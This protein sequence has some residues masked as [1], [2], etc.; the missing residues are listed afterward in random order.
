MRDV[1]LLKFFLSFF[2]FRRES[3]FDSKIKFSLP[4]KPLTNF[5][6][7]CSQNQNLESFDFP[8]H[9]PSFF[10]L[11]MPSNKYEQKTLSELESITRQ[12]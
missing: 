5:D 2:F 1:A 4:V 9:N 10:V 12:D 7:W 3:C 6:P 11:V 8:R